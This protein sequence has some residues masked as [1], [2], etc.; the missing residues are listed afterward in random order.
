M[1]EDTNNKIRSKSGEIT[2]G[3]KNDYKRM[4][5]MIADQQTR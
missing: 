4:L 5:Q 3:N 1:R 2:I